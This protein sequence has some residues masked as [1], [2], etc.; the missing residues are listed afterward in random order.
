MF[1]ILWT[2]MTISLTSIASLNQFK[3]KNYQ[4]TEIE[5]NTTILK[6]QSLPLAFETGNFY[7][8]NESD[9]SSIIAGI[10]T[11]SQAQSYLLNND[12]TYNNLDLQ[13]T[14]FIS[15]NNNIGI[16]SLNNFHKS[17]GN[18]FINSSF[19]MTKTGVSNNATAIET[20]NHTFVNFGDN[21]ISSDIGADLIDVSGKVTN[22]VP[23]Y[24]YGKG[25]TSFT[26]INNNFGVFVGSNQH[27]YILKNDGKITP[28][29][30]NDT[31]PLIAPNPI[32]LNCF[33]GIND[34]GGIIRDNNGQLFLLTIDGNGNPKTT[35]LTTDK[36]IPIF[37]T[38]TNFFS[39]TNN[40][41]GILNVNIENSSKF[42]GQ[43][44]TLDVTN[45]ND[46]K[47]M[48][49]NDH[50]M[51]NFIA[52]N[53]KLGVFIDEQQIGYFVNDLLTFTK[54]GFCI[55]FQKINDNLGIIDNNSSKSLL[56]TIKNNHWSRINT[57]NFKKSKYEQLLN[58]INSDIDKNKTTAVDRTNNLISNNNLVLSVTNN[59][60]TNI[61]INDDPPLSPNINN[62]I[63]TI[64]SS[65]SKVNIKF[66]DGEIINYQVLIYNENIL[67]TL[68]NNTNTNFK[69]VGIVNNN[70]YDINST[71]TN[72][73]FTINFDY[74]T[75]IQF[76]NIITIDSTTMNKIN[77]WTLK[78]K[79]TFKLMAKNNSEVYLLQTV[80]WNN[81]S[82]WQYFTIYDSDILPIVEF[83][84]TTAGIK[85]WNTALKLNYSVNQ[86]QSMNATQIDNLKKLSINWKI[87]ETHGNILGYIISSFLNISLILAI[88][89]IIYDW[90][91]KQQI[92]KIKI[93]N[94]L[95]HK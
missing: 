78:P 19:L 95:L 9:E 34:N 94:E 36:M 73:G 90:Y 4:K 71:N 48:K 86:L 38:T 30:I 29:M 76:V 91:L 2:L 67:P 10:F 1:K 47:V 31:K 6:E 44:Y 33:V 17:D 60:L 59:D 62:S 25:K 16:A 35:P 56:S 26:T 61:T 85:L 53:N 82:N 7:Q 27:C 15:F 79:T 50:Y 57:I 75:T 23:P 37:S 12:G 87:T 45:P 72:D 88:V 49:I 42:F 63:T 28:I 8:W 22:L 65:N 20:P 43:P 64:I 3:I 77:L 66:K 40:N 55:N 39:K 70:L 24:R 11:N 14:N 52:L 89:A 80:N 84:T 54:I 92:K 58:F 93:K 83:W 74:N 41:K 46:I 81:I 51:N 68:D 32:L 13:I 69:Y 18:N 5:E 21:I